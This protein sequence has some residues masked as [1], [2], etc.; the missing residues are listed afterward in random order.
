M[1]THYDTLGVSKTAT[2]AEIKKA[3]RKLAGQHHPD[4]GGDN[5]TFAKIN[6]ANDILSNEQKRAQYDAELAG[7]RFGGF[8]QQ[9]GDGNVHF[10]W[11]AGGDNVDISDILNSMRRQFGGYG[12]QQEQRREVN[13]DIRI[14]IGLEAASTLAEQK[15]TL[16]IKMP[17]G[18]EEAVEITIPRGVPDG[19]TIRYSGL[20]D[21]SIATAL[22]GDLYVLY[23]VTLPDGYQAD[24]IDIY[25][26]VIVNCL[27]A[28]IGCEREV[29]SLDGKVFS[30]KIPAGTQTGT[31]FAI[32]DQGLYAPN[33]PG[34]G[35]LIVFVDIFI[36]K[37]L[38]DDQLD[39]LRE[40][41][42]S[43]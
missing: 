4:K 11:G 18:K 17:N 42:A 28:M 24:G 2:Q 30:V 29:T 19:G 35:R 10:R 27:E 37:D 12:R 41:Q 20:G 34:R 7:P 33:H 39:K 36:L 1:T 15:R 31:K 26:E 21:N 9:G 6:Q 25:T 13:R 43:L 16:N 38:T 23:S 22:R 14:H 8:R 3:Y 32:A 40:L 5:E